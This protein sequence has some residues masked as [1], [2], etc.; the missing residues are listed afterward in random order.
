MTPIIELDCPAGDR[1][2][3]PAGHIAIKIPV[4]QNAQRQGQLTRR[5]GSG[6]AMCSLFVAYMPLG[7]QGRGLLSRFAEAVRR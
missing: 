6:R 2:P 3:P 4:W 5:S 7:K 1:T